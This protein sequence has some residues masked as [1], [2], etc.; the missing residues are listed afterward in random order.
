MNI[1]FHKKFK[2]SLRKQGK[3]I[4]NKFF[5]KLDLFVNDQFHYS[6]NNHALTGEFVG[7]RSIN[8]SGDVRVHY[9]EEKDGIVLMN[10]GKHSQ[11]Y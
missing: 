6:L 4:Q 1:R 10:I 3:K 2:K 11:L 5:S 9:Q 7:W 8:I